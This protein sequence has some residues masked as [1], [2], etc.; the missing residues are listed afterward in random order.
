[1]YYALPIHWQNKYHATVFETSAVGSLESLGELHS[2][3]DDDE[4]EACLLLHFGVDGGADHFKIEACSYNEADFRVPDQRNYQPTK[5][6]ILDENQDLNYCLQTVLP[7][8]S[9]VS[10]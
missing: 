10:W 2:T 9:I 1:M 5:L 3:V 7:V 8:D 4:S 6:A